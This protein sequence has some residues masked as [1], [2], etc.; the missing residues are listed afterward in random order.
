LRRN[1]L[2]HLGASVLFCLAHVAIMQALRLPAYAVMGAQYRIPD[3][4]TTLLYEYLKDVRGYVLILLAVIS[5]R[6]VLLRLQGEARLLDAP[7]ARPGEPPAAPP[8]RPERFLVRKLRRE[9][10]AASPGQLPGP[11]R[12]RPRLPVAFD[13]R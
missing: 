2:P 13:P 11:A 9:F 10:L 4:P 3:L 5:Y 1:L 7:D 12:E 8:T 6:L